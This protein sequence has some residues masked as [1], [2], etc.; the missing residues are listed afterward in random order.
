MIV[1]S[2]PNYAAAIMTGSAS[3]NN[4]FMAAVAAGAGLGMT[5]WNTSLRAAWEAFRTLKIGRAHV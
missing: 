3:T 5:V 1:K 4:N 2:V